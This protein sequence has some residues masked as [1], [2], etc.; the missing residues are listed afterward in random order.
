MKHD[1]WCV[2]KIN[3][4]L[5]FSLKCKKSEHIICLYLQYLFFGEANENT[6]RQG[7]IWFT[8]WAKKK[9]K[10]LITLF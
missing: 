6:D 3:K 9:K 1:T 7:E 2:K 10:T 5:Y 8:D 4:I